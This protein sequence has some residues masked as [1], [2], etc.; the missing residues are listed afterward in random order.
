MKD[1]VKELSNCIKVFTIGVGDEEV[2]AEGAISVGDRTVGESFVVCCLRVKSNF[3][4]L[5]S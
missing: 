4:F 3:L 2:F 1:K 5:K